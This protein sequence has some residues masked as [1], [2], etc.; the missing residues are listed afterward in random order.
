M[1]EVYLTPRRALTGDP[2]CRIATIGK[3]PPGGRIDTAATGGILSAAGAAG[4][5][6][7]VSKR[8]GD[9]DILWI[10]LA[11]GAGACF[12]VQASAN[13]SLRAH[14]HS[15]LWAA[16]F[17]ICGTILTAATVMLILRPTPPDAVAARGAPWWNWIGG[18]MGALIVLSGAALA[19][20]LGAAAFIAAVVGGQLACSLLLDHF[21]LMDLPR[22]VVTPGRLLGVL[23][24][25]AGVVLVKFH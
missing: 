3:A 6:A 24:V 7:R 1:G 16:F 23:L 20:R 2:P 15:P 25:F 8:R 4:A 5:A 18:P 9:V 11:A 22:Q 19:P 21:G 10:L 12:A 13:A 14:L 17:S